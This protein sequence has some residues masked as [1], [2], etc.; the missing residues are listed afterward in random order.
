MGKKK[1]KRVSGPR[2]KR[3]S[4]EGR[5]SSGRVWLRDFRGGNVVRAYRRHYGVAWEGAFRE[6]ELLGVKIDQKYQSAVLNSCAGQ[7]EARRW[8][9]LERNQR[10]NRVENLIDSDETFAF[11]AGYTPIGLPYGVTWEEWDAS[12]KDH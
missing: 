11:I 12:E 5:L 1:K 7:A 2:R 9:R 6:L 3:M 8:R 4:R 10:L